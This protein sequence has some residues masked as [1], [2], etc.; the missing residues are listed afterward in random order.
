[1]GE[2]TKVKLKRIGVVSLAEYFTIIWLIVGLI[3]AAMLAVL[4]AFVGS[5]FNLS[6]IITGVGIV[7]VVIVIPPLFALMGFIIGALA[8][9]IYN[10]IARLMGG[11]QMSLEEA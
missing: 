4:G 3:Y 9:I 2:V 8:A 6:S 1:M 7:V 11:V 10:L 5:L